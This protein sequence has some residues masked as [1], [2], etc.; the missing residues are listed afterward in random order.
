[1]NGWLLTGLIF[2]VIV[3]FMLNIVLF[4]LFTTFERSNKLK[5]IKRNLSNYSPKQLEIRID[6]YEQVIEL[7]ELDNNLRERIQETTKIMYSKIEKDLKIMESY[8]APIKSFNF[9]T[10][11]RELNKLISKIEEYETSYLECRFRLFDHT[12]DIE[13]EKAIVYSLKK[14]LGKVRDNTINNPLIVIREN[15]RLNSKLSK[16]S[17]EVK[18]I[19]NFVE[20][21]EKHLNEDFINLVKK[22]DKEI[23]QM[24]SSLDFMNSN[25]N[26]IDIDLKGPMQEIVRVYN[27]NKLILGSLKPEIT[28]LTKEINSFK[29]IVRDNI[30]ELKVKIVNENIAKLN[31]SFFKLN[32]LIR[33]NIDYSKFNDKYNNEYTKLLY[34]VNENNGLYVSEIKRYKLDDERERLIEISKAREEFKKIVDKFERLKLMKVKSYTPTAISNIILEIIYKYQ[35][36]VNAVERNINDINIVNDATNKINIEI[37][38]MNSLLLQVEYNISS[39]T[40]MFREKYENEKDHLQDYVEKLWERFKTNTDEIEEATFE[41]LKNFKQRILN[42]VS[43]TNGKSFELFFT[44]ETILFLNKYRGVNIKID[45]ILDKINDFFLEEKYSESLRLSKEMIEIYGIK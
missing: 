31:D 5:R 20:T 4:S 44:K 1:M 25:L 17:N 22:I 29:K 14:R 34:F 10:F 9:F 7:A 21:K 27:D 19:E 23:I 28:E 40:G 8:V 12:S 2:I 43:E 35:G 36:Y 41:K 32:L 45:D 11:K 37:G 6:K 30:P 26:H 24:A 18:K 42:L 3:L 15:K 39:L 13:I 16:I 33:S 38:S